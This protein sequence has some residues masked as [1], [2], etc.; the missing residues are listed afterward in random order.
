MSN[1]VTCVIGA[2]VTLAAVLGVEVL[3]MLLSG[4]TFRQKGTGVGDGER[5]QADV[6][7]DAEH[8]SLG[9]VLSYQ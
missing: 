6:G 8:S 5:R 1:A 4:W 2:M 3:F 9:S 7:K